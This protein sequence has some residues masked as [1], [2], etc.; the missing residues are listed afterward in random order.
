[1][2]DPRDIVVGRDGTTIVLLEKN[3]FN[4]LV[5]H[6]I[7]RYQVREWYLEDRWR[8]IQK[9]TGF[10][11]YPNGIAIDDTIYIRWKYRG[12]GDLIAHEYGHILGHGHTADYSLTMM[13]PVNTMRVFDPNDLRKKA[14]DN[15]PEYYGKYVSQTEAYQNAVIGATLLAVI[16]GLTG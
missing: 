7:K 10:G 1:M 6:I 13:N 14:Q 8:T 11:Y 15:F 9:K 3:D 5:E 2:Y 4:H 12:D 16:W